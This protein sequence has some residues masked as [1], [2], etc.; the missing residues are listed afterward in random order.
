MASEIKEMHSTM[1]LKEDLLI[2]LEFTKKTLDIGVGG[3]TVI[4]HSN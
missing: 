3:I 4:I 1:F 2:L